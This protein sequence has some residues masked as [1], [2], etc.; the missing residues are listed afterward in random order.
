M[1]FLSIKVLARLLLLCNVAWDALSAAAIWWSF[2]KR[3]V[4]D[5]MECDISAVEGGVPQMIAGMHT[6]MWTRRMDASNHAACMLMAWWVITLGCLRLLAYCY[7][8][9]WMALAVLSYGLEGCAF[10]IEALKS[11]MIPKKACPAALFSLF[12][13]LICWASMQV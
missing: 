6:S 4:S 7:H 1:T 2:C 8:E 10:C 3:D 12:C 11:T 13:L 5:D 9:E